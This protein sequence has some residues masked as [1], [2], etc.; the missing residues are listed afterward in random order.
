[1]NITVNSAP[2]RKPV[3][4]LAKSRRGIFIR[5]RDGYAY[6]GT[7]GFVTK[8]DT[9]SLEGLMQQDRDR[10]PVYEGDSI[11]ITF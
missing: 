1:M 6:F 10:Q 4:L 5:D 2:A 11:T 8:S 7:A 9:I 3:A